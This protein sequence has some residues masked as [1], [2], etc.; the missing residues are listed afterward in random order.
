[1][2]TLSKKSGALLSAVLIAFS[3][4]VGSGA[5]FFDTASVVSAE[6]HSNPYYY[7]SIENEPLA[8]KF[9]GAFEALTESGKF[10]R[11]KSNTI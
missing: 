2:K 8:Q 1:M 9:Y 7:E 5:F 4:T 10:K 6:D 3:A 11:A